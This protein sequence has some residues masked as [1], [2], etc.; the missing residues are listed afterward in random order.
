MSITIE[1]NAVCSCGWGNIW[2]V[3]VN[4]TFRG[5]IKAVSLTEATK[6]A[7]EILQ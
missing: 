5:F 6:K 7:K 4:N 3:N 2:A 1:K